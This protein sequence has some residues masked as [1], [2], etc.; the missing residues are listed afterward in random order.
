MLE[1]MYAARGRGLAAPQVGRQERVFV[2]DVTWK[3]GSRAPQVL[4]NPKILALAGARVAGPEACLSIPG[5]VTLVERAETV[6]LSWTDLDGGR[7]EAVLSG[8]AAICAQHECDHL[9]GI[10]TL[11]RLSPDARARAEAEVLA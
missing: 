7:N 10:L 4:V 11:D 5:P 8:F 6:H 2:M 3:E 1:T 9:D